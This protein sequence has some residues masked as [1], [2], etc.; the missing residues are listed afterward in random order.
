[1]QTVTV[2]PARIRAAWKGRISGCM[3]GKPVEV[4]S[5]QQGPTGLEAYLREARALPLRDF[6]P[7]VEG[8]IVEQHGTACCR[9]RIVR[10]EPDDDIN[11]TVLA[12]LL[13]EEKGCSFDTADVARAWLRLLPAGAT[14]TAE[15][16]AYRT[17]LCNMA[18]E[19]VNGEEAGFDLAECSDNDYNEWIGAQI[20]ADL[21]GWVCPGRPA[22]AAELARRDASLSHR[23]E[24]VHGAAFIAALGA[25]I[26]A[27]KNFATAIDMALEHIPFNSAAATAVRFG[28]EL[29]GSPDAVIRLHKN[30]DGMSPVHTLNNLALVVWAI[31]S[32]NGDFGTAIGD[33]VA[34][35]WDTDCNG[36]TVG[37]LFGLTGAEIPE[38]WTQPWQGRIGLN[39]AGFAELQLDDVV[40]RTVAVAQKIR[41]QHALH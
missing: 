41:E 26:P 37:G 23:G 38:S 15:R 24:G 35:G 31:C 30:Y 32:A 12:L 17:L 21:Y 39:L 7:L 33:A 5:L 1:M 27:T 20:R 25:A 8:S 13:L 9:G 11:Y 34:A 19:F 36:A 10:A 28:C 14:W 29:S 4:L 3:L 22:L 18:D 6:V 2:E 16:A 40:S